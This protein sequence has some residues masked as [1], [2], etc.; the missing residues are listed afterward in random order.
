MTRIAR[1]G[2]IPRWRGGGA[3][4]LSHASAAGTALST[5]GSFIRDIRVIRGQKKPRAGLRGFLNHEWTRIDA[6][7]KGLFYS[8]SLA[9]IRGCLFVLFVDLLLV[10]AP[11][12]LGL[13]VLLLPATDWTLGSIRVS[14]PSLVRSDNSGGC[15]RSDIVAAIR[16]SPPMNCRS[17]PPRRLQAPPH[18]HPAAAFS[19]SSSSTR[20]DFHPPPSVTAV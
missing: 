9:S 2:R 19:R 11:A 13:C 15:S 7:G 10:A 12:A 3:N 6:N 14:H 18:T 5:S 4:R 8:R 16:I 1:M 17:P 20:L